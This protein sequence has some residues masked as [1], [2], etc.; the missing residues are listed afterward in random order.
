MGKGSTRPTL[1]ATIWLYMLCRQHF[2]WIRNM[3]FLTFLCTN[4]AYTCIQNRLSFILSREKLGWI[5]PNKYIFLGC[6]N[7]GNTNVFFI[8]FIWYGIVKKDI[9]KIKRRPLNV[10]FKWSINRPPYRVNFFSIT[11]KTSCI[12]RLQFYWFK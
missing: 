11:F 9:W 4:T 5:A 2:I 8:G 1:P 3:L 7:I 10:F 6:K 12:W